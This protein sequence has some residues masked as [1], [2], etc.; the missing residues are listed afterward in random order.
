AAQGKMFER[1]GK[2]KKKKQHR[3]LTPGPNRSTAGRD[4]EHQKMDVNSP[5]F[6]AFPDFLDRKPTPSQIGEQ[7]AGQRPWLRSKQPCAQSAN[8]AQNRRRE[9]RLPLVD[10]VRVLEKLYVP[11]HDAGQGDI[12][13]TPKRGRG[14]TSDP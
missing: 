1:T 3:A 12:P 10:F 5:F 4:C 6:Q 11:L 8:A 7:V 14:G 2:R 13:P 9:L